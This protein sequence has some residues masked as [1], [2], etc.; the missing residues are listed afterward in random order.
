LYRDLADRG[1]ATS[2]ELA[3]R[4]GTVEQYVRLW[5]INQAAG[6]YLD[7][8]TMWCSTRSLGR[9]QLGRRGIGVEINPKFCDLAARRLGKRRM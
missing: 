4:T 8:P 6:G 3:K 5:L 2:S 1:P 7:Y 9:A